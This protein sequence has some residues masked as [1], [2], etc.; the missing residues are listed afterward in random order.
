MNSSNDTVEKIFNI[1]EKNGIVILPFDVGYSLSCS[2]PQALERIIQL[3][4]RPFDRPSVILGTPKIF[5]ELTNSKFKKKAEQISLPIGLIDEA[6]H[7]SK[8]FKLIPEK[9]IVNDSIA[10]FINMGGLANEL[11]EYAFSKGKI[12]YGSSANI[13]NSGNHYRLKDVESEIRKQVDLEIDGGESKYQEIRSDGKGLS[14][15]II[16]LY[17]RKV[18]RKGLLFEKIE[19]ET[20]KLGMI[21]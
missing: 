9:L 4:K 8:F 19:T 7:D 21:D 16:N 13:S 5:A 15:T 18:I 1:V 3:K 6:N 10:V 2:S 11:A 17:E 20:K 14:S 12:I